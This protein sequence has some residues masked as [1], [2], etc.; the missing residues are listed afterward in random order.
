[1]AKHPFPGFP[2]FLARAAAE[3]GRPEAADPARRI[4]TLAAVAN[5]C[6]QAADAELAHVPAI[7]A[8]ATEFCDQLQAAWR[9]AE[10]MIADL[11][12]GRGL[13][14]RPEEQPLD[15]AD[16]PAET[17]SPP[18]VGKTKARRS[19]SESTTTSRGPDAT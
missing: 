9:A 12:A 8:K 3:I 10:L 19:R 15:R 6:A 5:L 14:P 13:D 17:P 11:R 16:E 18:L 2:A 1:V 7:L 4:T